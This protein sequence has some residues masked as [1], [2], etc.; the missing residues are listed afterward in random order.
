MFFRTGVNEGQ[1]SEPQTAKFALA[2]QL[3]FKRRRR[4]RQPMRIRSHCFSKLIFTSL[5]GVAAVAPLAFVALFLPTTVA[6]A[7]FAMCRSGLPAWVGSPQWCETSGRT[8]PL[9]YDAD[10]SRPCRSGAM[11]S[12]LHHCACSGPHRAVAN[13]AAPATWAVRPSSPRT[14]R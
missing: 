4:L 1:S 13:G 7:Q 11:Q 9:S 5:A 12:D 8:Q 6:E 10:G 3:V 14:K 2:E